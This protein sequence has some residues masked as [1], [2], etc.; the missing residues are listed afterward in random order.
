MRPSRWAAIA[1]WLLW[2]F[3]AYRV[4]T[5]WMYARPEQSLLGTWRQGGREIACRADG[6]VRSGTRSTLVTWQGSRFIFSEAEL[7][8]VVREPDQTAWDVALARQCGIIR[9]S[10]DLFDGPHVNHK[11]VG[12][13]IEAKV[14]W[15]GQNRFELDGL[16]Y[17]RVKENDGT[18]LLDAPTVEMEK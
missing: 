14:K 16:C 11:Q 8:A 6:S 9:S 7:T 18:D 4:S 15:D 5:G 13:T 10:A 1:V 2:L 3:L 17:T 12:K